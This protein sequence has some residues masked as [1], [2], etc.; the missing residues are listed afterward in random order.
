MWGQIRTSC[1]ELV[2]LG[3]IYVKDK[4]QLQLILD[5]TLAYATS[6]DLF[7]KPRTLISD[8]AG[9]IASIVSS[10]SPLIGKAEAERQAIAHSR[11]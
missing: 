3:S 1:K 7:L 11:S 9:R 2:T 5:W 8:K 10:L 4:T 6:M